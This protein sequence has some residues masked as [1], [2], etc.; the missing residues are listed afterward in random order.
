[1]SKSTKKSHGIS[2]GTADANRLAIAILEVL[3]GVRTP[4]QAA[5][6]L[7]ISV[8]RYYQLETRALDGLV[9]ACE[10][11][12]KGKQPSPEGKIA[13]LERELDRVQRECGRQQALVRVAQRSIGLKSPPPSPKSSKQEGRRKRRPTVRALKAAE[14][15]RKNAGPQNGETLQR[16]VM[17]VVPTGKT[18][19]KED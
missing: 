2:S 12:S 3:A 18:S 4:A 7:A 13:A 11:R 9:S 5:E 17:D 19:A 6:A 16:A 14:A 15:L 8:P 1:M 10:P